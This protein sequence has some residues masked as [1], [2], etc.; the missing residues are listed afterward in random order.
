M[1]LLMPSIL[2]LTLSFFAPHQSVFGQA[3]AIERFFKDYQDNSDF[4]VVYVSPKMFEMFTKATNGQ[5]DQEII[6]IVKD[7]KGLRVLTT[8]ANPNKYYNEA[9]NR[10]NLNMYQ[11]LITVRDKGTN[12]RFVTKES[13][14]IIEELVLLVGGQ[15]EF[16]LMSF[17]GKIDLNKIA[18]LAS[19]L[20][21]NGAEYLDKVNKK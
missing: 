21:L 16:V 20:D 1:K 13:N 6:D 15:N 2:L 4:S 7:L 9:T 5:K 10:I 17:V 8:K 18:K 14:D 11:E 12:V 19:K 3:D